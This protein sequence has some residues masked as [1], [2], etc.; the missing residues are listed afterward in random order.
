MAV[1]ETEAPR[2][3]RDSQDRKAG[4]GCSRS[5]GRAIDCVPAA[6][7]ECLTHTAT[8]PTASPKLAFGPVLQ[9]SKER[10]ALEL[11]HWGV[12]DSR[13]GPAPQ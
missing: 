4:A 5:P 10:L 12:L 3:V 7:R 8:I 6:Q 2:E 9:K 1:K 13:P 11:R